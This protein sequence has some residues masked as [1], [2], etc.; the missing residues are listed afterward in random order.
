ML[1]VLLLAVSTTRI[2]AQ[3]I[4]I[5]FPIVE[6]EIRNQH[7]AGSFEDISFSH[8]PIHLTKSDTSFREFES[9][10]SK[11]ILSKRFLEFKILP[12]QQN[13]EFNSN[14]PF[15]WNNSA[16][17]RSRGLQSLTSAG[18]YSRIGPLILQVSP[19]MVYAQN[20]KYPSF[21]DTYESIWNGR[22]YT[23]WNLSDFPE[24]FGDGSYKRVSLGNSFIS[25]RIKKWDLQLSNE[26]LW[27]GPGQT[28]S[29]TMTNNAAGFLHLSL[30][31]NRGIK[32]PIGYFYPEL[33][34][35]K[36]DK[37]GYPANETLQW[38]Y[39]QKRRDWRY[40]SAVNISYKPNWFKGFE[41]GFIRTLQ[42]YYQTTKSE[43]DYFPVLLSISREGTGGGA[44]EIDQQASIYTHFIF[45]KAKGEVYAEIGRNDSPWD[46][47]DFNMSPDHALAY[48]IGFSKQFDIKGHQSHWSTE[49]IKTSKGGTGLFRDEPP[50]YLNGLVNHGYTHGGEI[51]G[52]GL[53][54]GSNA[55][56]NRFTMD[57]R[58]GKVGFQ[59]DRIVNEQD[60]YNEV[61]V[62]NG[63]STPW[64]DLVTG[65]SFSRRLNHLLIYS[66]LNWVRSFNYMWDGEEFAGSPFYQEKNRDNIFI[67]IQTAYSF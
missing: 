38:L 45:P 13:L 42:Q 24:Y 31:P 20:K 14:Y 8:R 33:L 15:G 58:L 55:L 63:V 64:V 53:R 19:M 65:V 49:V 21:P 32:T 7:T 37:S 62:P 50:W 17:I 34:V 59:F 22:V 48:V 29:L 54:P 61:M 30:K 46:I 35:G 41:I 5:D 40:L 12:V 60:F 4:P 2:A 44:D 51:V 47:R 56:N 43:K 10:I 1:R 3:S 23:I 16:M 11:S 39:D 28:H 52:S 57:T 25:L 9:T 66:E 67:R 36:L 26:N 6:R 27:W 18:F